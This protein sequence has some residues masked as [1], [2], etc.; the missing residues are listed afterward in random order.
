M[1]HVKF[2]RELFELQ[3]FDNAVHSDLTVTLPP[4]R[5]Q[6]SPQSRPL[7]SSSQPY[8]RTFQAFSSPLCFA[9]QNT[10]VSPHRAE[11]P[12]SEALGKGR[13]WIHGFFQ[14]CCQPSA[15]SSPLHCPLEIELHF[16]FLKERKYIT[17]IWVFQSLENS[18]SQT[19][20]LNFHRPKK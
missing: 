3:S 4:P 10:W 14:V 8:F 5:I 17:D 19:K 16:S 6:A 12:K 11:E 20:S 9:S 18:G 13:Q 2:S 7:T 1:S 15:F